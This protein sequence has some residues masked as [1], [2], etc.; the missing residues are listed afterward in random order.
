MSKSAATD[1]IGRENAELR[2]LVAAL[3]HL[4]SLAVQDAGLESVV[5]FVADRADTAAAV[6]DERLAVLVASGGAR[7]EAA[8]FFGE[9]LNHPRLAQV[10]GVVGPTRRALRI[11]AIA[12]VAPM[13]VAPIPVGEDIPAFLLTLDDGDEQA[14]GEM[15]LLLTEHAA[16]VCGV[17]LG[18][19]RVV[20]AA[21]TRAR[22]NL[23]EGLLSGRGSN[24]DEIRRWAVHLGY[25]ERHHHRVV[26]VVLLDGYDSEDRKRVPAAVERFF[27]TQAPD[28]I[29]TQREREVVIVMP[30]PNPARARTAQL[31]TQ[32]IK[33][34]AESF[35]HA[36][37]NAGIGGMCHSALDV[38]RSYEDARRTAEISSRLGRIGTTVAV[39]DLGIHRLLLQVP[40][41]V[42]LRNFAQ[43]VFG[44][45]LAQG[46]DTAMEY[47]STLASY[48]RVN[49]SPQRAAEELHMHR[50]TVTYRIRRVEELTGLD[51]HAYRDRLMAQVALEIL[52][53]MD[54]MAATS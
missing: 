7:S 17:I 22:Q 31:T 40:D 50:N 2:Q 37:I 21:A 49:N 30:E 51:F 3:Q 18:R 1:A 13:I 41:I 24:N 5:E 53:M 19:E 12:R 35:G 52:D 46:N 27:T 8:R 4:S 23:V 34:I 10:L 26:T 11:P 39:E 47:L 48:F 38:A 36:P 28:A 25:D 20:A 44:K 45:L 33:R 14:G 42:E 9:Q 29:T 32:C 16:T 6:V 43:E 54:V 15:R